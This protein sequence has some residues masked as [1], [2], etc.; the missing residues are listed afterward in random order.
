MRVALVVDGEPA[1]TMTGFASSA[2]TGAAILGRRPT[3]TQRPVHAG[4]SLPPSP[5]F[6]EHGLA[7]RRHRGRFRRWA[8]PGG[9]RRRI[10]LVEPPLQACI[11]SIASRRRSKARALNLPR[12]TAERDV[13]MR[14]VRIPGPDQPQPGPI[15]RNLLAQ[16]PLDRRIDQHPIDIRQGRRE[17]QKSNDSVIPPA[18]LDATPIRPDQAGLLERLPLGVRQRWPRTHVQADINLQSTLVTDMP[19]PHRTAARVGDIA[20]HQFGQTGR[21]RPLTQQFDTFQ[22]LR[23]APH[24]A[25]P[26][27]DGREANAAIRQAF[28]SGNTTAGRRAADNPQRPRG[29]RARGGSRTRG[30]DQKGGE[31]QDKQSDQNRR[32]RMVMTSP[33]RT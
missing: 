9:C 11:A 16:L 1:P 32:S 5:P 18:G 6:G 21:R 20:D 22:G 12:R 30:A 19:A 13:H 27:P 15:P 17:P 14:R 29:G 4:P 26:H 24:V 31:T 3:Q 10:Q 25:L 23:R 33:G 2:P 7:R 8:G 28:G